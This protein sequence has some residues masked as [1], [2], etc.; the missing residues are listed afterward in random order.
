MTVAPKPFLTELPERADWGLAASFL[1]S[2]GLLAGALAFQH[3]GGMLP[4]TLCLDQ[5][6]VH[7]VALA[8]AG[9]GG[10]AFLMGQPLRRIAPIVLLILSL[11]YLYSGGLATY[12]AGVEWGLWQGPKTCSDGNNV[13]LTITDDLLG[14]L[15]NDK[16]IP[17]CNQAAWR[18]LGI[19]MAGYNALVSFGLSL[20]TGFTAMV[21]MTMPKPGMVAKVENEDDLTHMKDKEHKDV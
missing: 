20:L 3:I 14:S 17:S 16:M 6:E 13:D 7:W 9:L 4:C 12:H 2:G 1:I 15:E 8:L 19:S 11:V 18:L 5:R 10:I 21:T